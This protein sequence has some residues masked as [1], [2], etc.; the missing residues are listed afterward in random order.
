MAREIKE[1]PVL[2]GRSAKE[3][4][5]KIRA[6]ENRPISKESYARAMNTYQNIIK[7]SKLD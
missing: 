7:S 5:A 6:E 2:T 3:F 1:T 4:A